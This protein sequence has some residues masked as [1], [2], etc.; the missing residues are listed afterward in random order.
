[1]SNFIFKL[2]LSLPLLLLLWETFVNIYYWYFNF[3]FIIKVLLLLLWSVEVWWVLKAKNMPLP[4][5]AS[6][7][8]II[9][10]GFVIDKPLEFKS[11]A[12]NI[13]WATLYT[14]LLRE[15]YLKSLKEDSNGTRE[16]SFSSGT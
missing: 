13:L 6:A 1:M 9:Y 4:V 12:S 15:Y 5:L 8:V 11:Y 16:A 3:S 7:F 10:I 14:Y 2:L